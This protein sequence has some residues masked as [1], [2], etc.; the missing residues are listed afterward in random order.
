MG[1]GSTCWAVSDV[2][3]NIRNCNKI[4]EFTHY[5]AVD[6]AIPLCFVILVKNVKATSVIILRI[7]PQLSHLMVLVNDISEIMLSY[8]F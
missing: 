6:S 4:R 3:Y 2:W 7:Q 5:T 8:I 1:V